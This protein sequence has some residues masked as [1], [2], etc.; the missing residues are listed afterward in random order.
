[1]LAQAVYRALNLDT[2]IFIPAAYPPHKPQDTAF[3]HRYA[4]VQRAVK[5]L[6]GSFDISDIEGSRPGPSYTIDTLKHFHSAYPEAELWW[7]L[8]ED[9]LQNLHHWHAVESFHHYTRFVVIARKGYPATSSQ[10]IARYLPHL[11]HHLDRVENP[12]NSASSTQIR[13]ALKHTPQQRPP[14]L[15][16]PVYTYI[17]EHQLYR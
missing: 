1:M 14:F 8:G 12:P 17:V 16:L 15:P 5:T 10:H 3:A 7:L 2:L 13:H 6:T 9:A 4:M 11:T